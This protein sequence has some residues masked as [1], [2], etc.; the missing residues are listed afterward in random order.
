MVG[1]IEE[2]DDHEDEDGDDDEGKTYTSETEDSRNGDPH[3]S[4]RRSRSWLSG[5][6]GE[7][8]GSGTDRRAQTTSLSRRN[9]RAIPPR[10]FHLA[11]PR[12]FTSRGEETAR[13]GR[14]ASFSGHGDQSDVSQSRA[15][16]QRRNSA[17]VGGGGNAPVAL[18]DSRSSRATSVEDEMS[19][20]EGKRLSVDDRG[21]R[22]SFGSSDGSGSES[23]NAKRKMFGRRSG[24]AAVGATAVGA[25]KGATVGPAVR[26]S[27]EAAAILHAEP[28]PQAANQTE[29]SST[30]RTRRS[31]SAPSGQESKPAAAAAGEPRTA[32]PY[33]RHTIAGEEI[34]RGAPMSTVVRA[35]SDVRPRSTSLQAARPV[36]I[37]QPVPSR[38]M[39]VCCLLV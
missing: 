37:G 34:A 15:S 30:E 23:E 10:A 32:A 29:D 20:T 26:L 5:S 25:G 24:S 18:D 17:A 27:A 13:L 3:G 35:G 22:K 16:V 1:Y 7:G 38:W 39:E 4:E 9:S 33:T 2:E 21:R 36:P 19:G 11:P 8:S 31:M 14:L 28:S 6:D 12:A